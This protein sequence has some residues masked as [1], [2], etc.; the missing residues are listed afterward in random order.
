MALL[1]FVKHFLEIDVHFL[2]LG[3]TRGYGSSPCVL[4]RESGRRIPLHGPFKAGMI[5]AAT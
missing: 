5:A 3:Q 4:L 1:D 2:T